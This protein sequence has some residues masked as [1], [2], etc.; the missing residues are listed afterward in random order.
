[1]TPRSFDPTT[2]RAMLPDAVA[3][4]IEAKARADAD[5]GE[6]AFDPPKADTVS[7]WSSCQLEFERAVYHEQF[8][9]R[10]ARIE[11]KS[12]GSNKEGVVI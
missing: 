2:S 3:R 8:R 12:A 4:H 1:M 6:S 7:Y 10:L 9:K 11:R 5:R